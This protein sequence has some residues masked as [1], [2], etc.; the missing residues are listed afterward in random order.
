MASPPYAR[1]LVWFRRD[2]RDFDHAAL[3]EAL[4]R[5]RAVFAA[6]VFDREILD[7][8]PR[9]DRRVEFIRESLVELD[10]A[11]VARGGGLVV[12]H[13]LAREAVPALAQELGVDAV[14]AN[15]DYEPAAIARDESVAESLQAAGIAFETFKDQ[16]IFERGEIVSQSG[17]PYAVFTPYRNAWTAALTP[18]H[19]RSY[20]APKDAGTLARPAQ[21]TGVPSLADLGFEA[22]GLRATGVT[23]GMSGGAALFSAFRARIDDYRKSRDIPSADGTSRLS[24]HLRFG[25]VSVRELAAYAHARSLERGGEG[26]QTWLSELVW[27]EFFAQILWHR[28][29]V[30]DRSFR[31][32]YEALQWR[33]DR[34]EFAAWCEG[35]TGYPIVDAA[36]RELNTTGF[37]HNRLR[38]V[39]ASFLVK[40]LLV[41]WRW[42]ERYFAQQ[43]LD[44]DLA[45]NNGNW[46]WAASTGCDA[47]PYFRIFNPVS[48]SERFDPDGAFIRRFVTELRAL[49]AGEI[50]APWK[51]PPMVQGAKGVVIGRDY[52]APVVDHAVSRAQ[53]LAMFKAIGRP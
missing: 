11:L 5:A 21:A 43:L 50:H 3:H 19:L 49:D 15:R 32:E 1:A 22:T 38:M 27:R 41:D 2:L 48:Q 24:V 12:R 34:A 25:T 8:L 16:V 30:V 45:S 10:A 37:M 20:R 23:P 52:P 35:R 40:D 26:A 9:R 33:N 14:F 53:A 17:R 29:D 4:S 39:A 28:P 6:F 46:Q 13:G 44:Y 47:Q 42:G 36:M 31:P 18:A 7:P 51:L